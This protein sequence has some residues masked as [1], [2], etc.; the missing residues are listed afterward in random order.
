MKN[1]PLT[2][3]VRF[4][5]SRIGLRQEENTTPK[6][7]SKPIHSPED[8]PARLSLH[9]SPYSCLTEEELEAFIPSHQPEGRR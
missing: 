7:F 6:A 2:K 8:R 3:G 5:E 1:A 9:H 4:S